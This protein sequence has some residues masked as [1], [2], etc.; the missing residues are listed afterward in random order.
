MPLPV[1]VADR[2]IALWLTLASCQPLVPADVAAEMAEAMECLDTIAAMAAAL[3]SRKPEA[4][5]DDWDE[6]E[7]LVDA[8]HAH[9]YERPPQES[10]AQSGSL[11]SARRKN[12]PPLGPS[13]IRWG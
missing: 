7:E 13:L 2:S 9:L 10:D 6:V 5:A 3:G 4:R 12:S 11:L 8:V 1:E